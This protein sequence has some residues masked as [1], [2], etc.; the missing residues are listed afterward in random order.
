MLIKKI[1]DS[2]PNA[3]EVNPFIGDYMP[4]RIDSE[5]FLAVRRS[6][7]YTKEVFLRSLRSNEFEERPSIIF[8]DTCGAKHAVF[9]PNSERNGDL[10]SFPGADCDINFDPD[11]TKGWDIV[12][13]KL[14]FDYS[15]ME[16]AV[17]KYTQL[18]STPDGIKKLGT[19]ASYTAARRAEKDFMDRYNAQFPLWGRIKKFFKFR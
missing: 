7:G 8:E 3:V 9:D 2:Y 14:E 18:I 12:C 15:F 5:N 11:I 16:N 6:D 19:F 1:K 10:H 13:P 17:G 4:Y